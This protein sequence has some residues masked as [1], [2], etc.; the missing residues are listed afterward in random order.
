MSLLEHFIKETS[1]AQ[2]PEDVFGV[3]SKTVRALGFDCELYVFINS[4]D[5]N[6]NNPHKVVLYNSRKP[7]VEIP[8]MQAF[9][10]IYFNENIEYINA[11][12]NYARETG[13][14][15]QWYEPEQMKR[16]PEYAPFRQKV[17]S[18][19][20]TSGATIPIFG[21]GN[22]TALV[23]IANFQESPEVDINAPEIQTV[24][25]MAYHMHERVRSLLK[26]DTQ[27]PE[28]SD[29]EMEVLKWV[30]RGKSDSVIAEI[31]GISEHTVKTY[32]KRCYQKLQVANRV[33]AVARALNLGIILP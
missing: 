10:D 13:E 17:L 15:V 3:F 18:T 23:S 31:M 25:L 1:F 24:R 14:I 16:Y 4:N 5:L 27:K 29:R 8:E 28:L 22:E 33:A 9:L 20:L 32:M 30:M 19:G 2:T 6:K 11:G 12:H 7:L 26:D 21:L